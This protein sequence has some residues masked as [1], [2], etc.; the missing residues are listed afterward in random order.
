MEEKKVL[1]VA[2]YWPPSSGSGVQ[3]WLKFVKYLPS[4][5]WKP[6]VFTPANP[7]VDSKDESLSK[8][9]PAEAEVIHF[10]I[11]E[12][13]GLF[14]IFSGKNKTDNKVFVPGDKKQSLV[15]TI[16]VWIRGNFI[17]PDPRVFWVRPAVKFLSGYLKENQI[18]TLI[19]TGPPHSI[20]LIGLKLK[21]KNPSLKWLAD[22]RDP[23]SEWG[24]LDSIQSGPLAKSIHRRLEKKVLQRADEVITI[25]PFYVKQLERLS[26]RA[27]RLLTNG[28]DDSD[29][30]NFKIKKSNKF[31]VR[32]IGIV[33]EKCDPRPFM[34][35]VGELCMSNIEIKEAITI[36]FVGTVHPSFK[37]FVFQDPT[38]SSI[39]KFTNAV[40][41]E[42]LI[43]L[44]ASS[45]VLVLILTGYKDAEGYMPGKLFEYMA[46]GLPIL[47]VGPITGDAA[48]ILQDAGARMM[49]AE[50]DTNG[51]QK[52]LELNF[53][54]WKTPNHE[55]SKNANSTYSRKEITRTLSTLLNNY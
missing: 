34:K 29:F 54:K 32:H 50:N 7:T 51:I 28:F 14:N 23:W 6:Y 42:A 5:G 47:G 26:G 55:L 16:G 49:F 18:T 25:T 13:Y 46:T 44:Y 45:A 30:A 40:P 33:N 48:A 31:Y 21:K 8:D 17:L 15:Q 41:H 27:V 1:I 9:V 39:T 52:F 24:F 20:H 12:P 3:R 38:L 22:F 53:V 10:P 37:E 19:T 36:E 35:A 4:L 43:E 11:W 2:Y